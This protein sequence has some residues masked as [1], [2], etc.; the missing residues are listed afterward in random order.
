MPFADPEKRR[1][2]GVRYRAAHRRE[3]Y[4]YE[5][6]RYGHKRQRRCSACREIGH[7]MRTCGQVK[8]AER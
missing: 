4:E 8:G 6:R 1:A 2:Y 7:N 3:R 5:R